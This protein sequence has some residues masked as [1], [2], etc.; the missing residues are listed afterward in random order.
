MHV[1]LTTLGKVGHVTLFNSEK[2]SL[3]F[4]P[5]RTKILGFFAVESFWFAIINKP[6]KLLALFMFGVLFAERAVLGQGNPVGVVTLVFITVVIAVLA[7][8]ALQCYFCPYLRFGCHDGKLRTKKLHPFLRC[9]VSL[10]YAKGGCQPFLAGFGRKKEKKERSSHKLKARL[11]FNLSW[12][13]GYYIKL[14][15]K[16]SCRCGHCGFSWFWGAPPLVAPFLSA[17]DY[18][19]AQLHPAE[20]KVFAN[21]VRWRKSVVLLAPLIIWNIVRI[22][23]PLRS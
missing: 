20:A 18:I 12:V 10:T 6:R 4:L 11:A 21:W 13:G 2:V 22:H 7:L 14:F 15:T 19:M 3:S 23:L 8:R 1:V 16:S 5:I 17:H 9:R